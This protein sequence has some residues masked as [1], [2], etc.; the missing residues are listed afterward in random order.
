MKMHVAAGA[1]GGKMRACKL[2][3]VSDLLPIGW[4]SGARIFLAN[5]RAWNYKRINEGI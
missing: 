2:Q 1:K 3:E 4:E 5:H